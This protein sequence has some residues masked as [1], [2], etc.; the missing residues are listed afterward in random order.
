MEN[1]K[2]NVKVECNNCKFKR[3][4]VEIT[5]G[6][7]S[8][9]AGSSVFSHLYNHRE[10][11]IKIISKDESENNKYRFEDGNIIKI[12]IYEIIRKSENNVKGE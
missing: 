3:N 1:Y 9:N 2:K 7:F 10:H 5:L 11:I 8:N 4:N 12:N 6:K